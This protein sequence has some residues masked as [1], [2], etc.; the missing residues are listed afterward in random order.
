[1]RRAGCREL[2][3][4]TPYPLVQVER[5]LGLGSSGIPRACAIAA[6]LGGG[7]AYF[8]QWLFEAYLYPLNVGG[9]PAH[10]PLAFAIITFE[11]A[12]LAAALTAFFGVLFKGGLPALWSRVDEIAGFENVTKDRYWLA[13]TGRAARDDSADETERQLSECEPMRIV[14]IHAGRIL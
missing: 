9:R 4:Y 2:D 10:F 12:V 8:L 5:A 7:L 14:R 1:M 6:L 13:I 11:M 3:A